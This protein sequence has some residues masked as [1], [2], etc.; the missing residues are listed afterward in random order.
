[1]YVTVRSSDWNGVTFTSNF[2]WSK[3][4]GTG[5]IGQYNSSY[6]VVDPYNLNASY[7]VNGYDYKIVYNMAMYYQPR[8][9][10]NLQGWKRTVL[11]GWTISPLFTAQSGVPTA[12]SYGPS[13]I[14]QAFGESNSSGSSAN[15]EEAVGAAPYT[16]GQ[17]AHYNVAGSGGIG[18]TNP[19]GVNMFADPASVYKEF[20]PCVLGVDTSC[21]GYIDFRGL[22]RWNLDAALAKDFSFK[23]RYGAEIHIQCTN[24]LNHVAMGTPSL[25]LTTPTQFGRI[26]GIANTPRQMEFGLRLHF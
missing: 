2:T 16:G 9:L 1:M 6:T 18:T 12:V 25:S 22:P 10:R 24:V 3:A 8:F 7:G 17:A 11:G 4:L 5:Q 21:G 23:E 26:T 19:F 13:S 14:T 20:R 15:T